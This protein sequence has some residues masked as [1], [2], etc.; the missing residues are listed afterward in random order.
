MYKNLPNVWGEGALFAFS[1]YEGRTDASFQIVSKLL[2]DRVGMSVFFENK[3]GQTLAVEFWVELPGANLSMYLPEKSVI[4][5][6]VVKLV[7]KNG[8]IC[9]TAVDHL[10][11]AGFTDIKNA[12]LIVKPVMKD[13]KEGRSR[14]AFVLKSKSN[15]IAVTGNNLKRSKFYFPAFSFKESFVLSVNKSYKEAAKHCSSILKNRS[16]ETLPEKNIRALSSLI[17]KWAKTRTAG[18]A[19]S[20]LKCNVLSKQGS[21]PCRWTTPDRYPHRNM[22]IWDSA[23]HSRAWEYLDSKMAFE[24]VNAV[25]SQQK[26]DGYIPISSNPFVQESKITTQPPILAWELLN[27]YNET[28]DAGILE[29]TYAKLEKFTGYFERK[30]M[31]KKTGLFF[32]KADYKVTIC[33]AGESGLDN[34]PLYDGDKVQLSCDLSVFMGNAYESMEKIASILNKSK[35]ELDVWKKKYDKTV[36]AINKYLWSEKNGFYYDREING[37]LVDVKSVTGFFPLF[38]GAV[39]KT[40]LKKL[41][42]HLKNKK[43][44]W[45]AFPLPTIAADSSLY[46]KD[47]WRGPTWIN[48][49]FIIA[50]GLLRYK[51]Y[52]AAKEIAEISERNIRHW[53]N[54]AGVIC[55][56]YDSENKDDPRFLPRKHYGGQGYLGVIRDY[57]WSAALYLVFLKYSKKSN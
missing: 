49:N 7:F 36:S 41:L 51:K 57:G 45:R 11:I 21:I 42:V 25:L 8:Q 16:A 4:A 47:M 3:K 15:S 33:R 27:I 1:G 34:S 35:N 13:Y 17:P 54:K 18:K 32:W 5:G 44:F 9:F 10:T 37:G 40:R 55:E 12:R 6:D 48:C 2:Y 20:I 28:K 50:E 52:N 46:A 43:E 26:K 31:H 29:E 14:N 30:R 56:Y 38:A 39:P 22:W 53:Y 24:S 23:F 19:V